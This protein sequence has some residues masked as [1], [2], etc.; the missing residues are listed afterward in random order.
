MD[1]EAF[2][3]L[4]RSLNNVTFVRCSLFRKLVVCVGHTGKQA[5]KSEGMAV[6]NCL[7]L[8]TKFI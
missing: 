1:L 4:K 5:A 6:S 7:L 8:F 3:D 2:V